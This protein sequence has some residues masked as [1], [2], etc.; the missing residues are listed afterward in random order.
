V[1]FFFKQLETSRRTSSVSGV[2]DESQGELIHAT[3]FN[4]KH[5]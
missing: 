2:P 3:G 1:A 4:H 5:R